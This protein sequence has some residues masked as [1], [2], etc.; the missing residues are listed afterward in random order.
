MLEAVTKIFSRCGSSDS[1]LPPTELY[2]EGWM[3]RLVLDWLDRNREVTHPLSFAHNARWYSEALLPSR[4]L[5]QNRGDVRAESFTHAD[6]IIGHFSILPGERGAAKVFR[7][8]K[9]LIV[10]EAKLGSSLSSGT[11]NASTFDQVARNVACIAHMIGTAGANIDTFDHLGFYVLAPEA[12]I[13]AGMFG[14]LI[15]RESVERKVRTRVLKYDGIFDAWFEE[16]FKP[17][18]ARI[19]LGALAWESVLDALPI[20]LETQQMWAFYEICLKFNPVR[21]REVV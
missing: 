7:D 11:K 3:L 4:F 14:D 19:K 2:N 6:G 13:R 9:Q 12:Q 16:M 17:V 5:P 21:R 18:L 10:T 8:A 1:V 20:T 15:T